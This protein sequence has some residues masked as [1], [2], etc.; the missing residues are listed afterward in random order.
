[1]A[2]ILVF[3]HTPFETPGTIADVLDSRG[4]ELETVH[5]YANDPVPEEIGAADALVVMG[6]PMGVYETDV[7]PF[8]HD[9]IEF[10]RRAVDGGVPTLGIC[11]GSQI[12]TT[13]LGGS[14]TKGSQ[15]EIGWAPVELSAAAASDPL[16][17]HAPRTW[18]VL[19]WHGDQI[20]PPPGAIVLASSGITPCQAFRHGNT[21]YGLQFHPE[22]TDAIV[23]GMLDAF[24]DEL[25]EEEIHADTIRAGAITYS[26]AMRPICARLTAEWVNQWVA[27]AR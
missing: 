27:T 13:A 14:V 18:M 1:M 9:E 4:F 12:L 6:G 15:K 11:L 26:D 17:R 25:I 10:V 7:V 20:T 3:Q 16:F 23:D 8:M 5:L 22:A 19:H 21:A 2:R 24:R